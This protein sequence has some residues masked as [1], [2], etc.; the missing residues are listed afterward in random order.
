[1]RFCRSVAPV[2]QEIEPQEVLPLKVLVDIECDR[3]R[4]ARSLSWSARGDGRAEEA[5][6]TVCRVR[7]Y[8][9]LTYRPACGELHRV[10]HEF[11]AVVPGSVHHVRSPILNKFEP[12]YELVVFLRAA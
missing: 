2:Q 6:G 11:V 7:S 4:K 10:G 12:G 5:R 1:M 9:G 8:R 3:Q